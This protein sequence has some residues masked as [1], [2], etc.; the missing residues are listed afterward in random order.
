MA[1]SV[2]ILGILIS[3]ALYFEPHSALADEPCCDDA[4][5][6]DRSGPLYLGMPVD[7][8]TESKSPGRHGVLV[9]VDGADSL[10][11]ACKS[12]GEG[13]I[14]GSD[15]PQKCRG[16]TKGDTLAM[17]GIE[18]SIAASDGDTPMLPTVLST[19]KFAMLKVALTHASPADAA[20]VRAQ[21]PSLLPDTTIEVLAVRQDQSSG[22]KLEEVGY[23]DSGY[24]YGG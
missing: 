9:A 3:V 19:S 20:A 14:A 23:F 15:R 21:E 22:A 6:F 2:S 12:Q 5:G 17:L 1:P 4:H 24:G 11:L 7:L 8:D 18:P 16:V 10:L 13:W